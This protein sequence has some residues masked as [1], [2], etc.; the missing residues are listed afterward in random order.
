MSE[1]NDLIIRGS[2][3]KPNI[4]NKVDKKVF[5]IGTRGPEHT[6]IKVICDNE[7]EAIKIWHRI[8]GRLI[9]HYR[10]MIDDDDFTDNMYED[11][12][13]N[14]KESN[15]DKLSN[16]PHSEPF[17]KERKVVNDIENV[18]FDNMFVS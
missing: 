6:S 3:D 9:K 2:L 18:N 10:E 13:D 11:M 15:P 14:L 5:I 1:A 8:R 12:I 4:S 7:K 17:I 16:Y